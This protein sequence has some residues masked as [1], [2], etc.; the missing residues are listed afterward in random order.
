M[1]RFLVFAYNNPQGGANDLIA[2]SASE[3]DA[4]IQAM[5]AESSGKVHYQVLD[6]ETGSVIARK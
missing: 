3:S 1:E 5:I 2:S 4:K 6:T